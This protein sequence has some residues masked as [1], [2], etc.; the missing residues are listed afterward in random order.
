MSSDLGVITYKFS[1]SKLEEIKKLTDNSFCNS[2][3]GNSMLAGNIEHE[4]QMPEEGHDIIN[5]TILSLVK[6]STGF[7]DYNVQSWINYQKKYEFNPLH[8]HSGEFSFVIWVRIP[9]N[10]KDEMNLPFVKNSRAPIASTFNLVYL[11]PTGDIVGRPFHLDKKDEGK[12][13][14]FPAKMHH[15]VYPFYTSDDYRVS[16]AGNLYI[17]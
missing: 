6:K 3:P 17:D 1:S 14:I 11:T 15:I 5:P 7:G 12:M 16:I 2:N 9:Y 13:I 8:N 10:L 4:Y